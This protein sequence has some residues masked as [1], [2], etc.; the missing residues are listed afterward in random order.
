MPL[1]NVKN[2]NKQNTILITQT[3]NCAT[4]KE[5]KTKQ[6]QIK[7][8]NLNKWLKNISFYQKE[9]VFNVTVYAIA[10]LW[11]N[12]TEKEKEKKSG[13]SAL[14]SLMNR[15]LKI[16]YSSLQTRTNITQSEMQPDYLQQSLQ[17]PIV[18]M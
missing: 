12:F 7:L 16:S 8:P 4:H 2:L 1:G 15:L 3:I 13:E 10:Y 6:A 14:T 9:L 18:Y 17:W 11:Y 5:Y